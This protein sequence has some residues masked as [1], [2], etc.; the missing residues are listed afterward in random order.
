[1]LDSIV[2]LLKCATRI[3]GWINEDALDLSGVF[4]LQSFESQQVIT[5]DQLVIKY[6][7][8]MTCVRMVR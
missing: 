5:E 2:I 8:S 4:G 6:I 7:R 1:M 3:I